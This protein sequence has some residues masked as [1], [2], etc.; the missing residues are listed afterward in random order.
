MFISVQFN[1]KHIYKNY[2][3][4]KI[5]KNLIIYLI[6]FLYKLIKSQFLINEKKLFNIL[7]KIKYY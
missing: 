3:L 4:T 1:K 2:I 7:L 6:K 5:F